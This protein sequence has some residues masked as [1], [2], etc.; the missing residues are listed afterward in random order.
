MKEIMEELFDI[1]LGDLEEIIKQKLAQYDY[2]V[3]HF[4]TSGVLFNKP[5][6]AFLQG[7]ETIKWFVS[8]EYIVALPANAGER[9]AYSLHQTGSKKHGNRSSAASF[10]AQLRNEKKLHMGYYRLYKY[11]NG[12]AFKRYEPIDENN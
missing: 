10:P 11:K 4:S 5:C 8:S 12:F 3:I 6:N 1:D 9:N 2:P 7:I